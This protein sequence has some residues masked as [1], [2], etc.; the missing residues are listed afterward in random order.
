MVFMTILNDGSRFTVETV[1]LLTE[2]QYTGI[3]SSVVRDILNNK[4]DVSA[5]LPEEVIKLL[6]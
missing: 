5:F 2:Q 4:G 3:S 6:I 1:F